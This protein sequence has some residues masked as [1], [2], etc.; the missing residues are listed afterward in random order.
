MFV[1]WGKRR[2]ANRMGYVADFCPL[3]RSIERFEL[4][5][6]GMVG[7]IYYL[8][9]GKG[10]LVAHETRCL[11]CNF[12]QEVD[13]TKFKQPAK[14]LSENEQL[15]SNTFPNIYEHY[16]ERLTTEETG[17]IIPRIPSA[18]LA[19]GC[20]WCLSNFLLLA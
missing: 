11:A 10:Q 8:S 20:S 9:I 15:V 4:S 7:H 5:R 13:A 16:R 17:G 12:S 3:C 1:V 2:V 14:Q 6:V 18:E 19:N